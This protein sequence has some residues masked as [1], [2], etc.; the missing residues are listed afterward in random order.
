ML[1]DSAQQRKYAMIGFGIGY[2][3]RSQHTFLNVVGNVYAHQ[4]LTT[5]E[6]AEANR[7]KEYCDESQKKAKVI[8][9]MLGSIIK[10]RKT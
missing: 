2:Y 7:P 6:L 5:A 4:G 9:K 3:S 1:R 8:G 10:A